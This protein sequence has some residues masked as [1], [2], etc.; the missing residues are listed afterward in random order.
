MLDVSCNDATTKGQA[1]SSIPL[2]GALMVALL[3]C[4]LGFT[5]PMPVAVEINGYFGTADGGWGKEV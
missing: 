3:M 4:Q 1:A 2:A 5:E